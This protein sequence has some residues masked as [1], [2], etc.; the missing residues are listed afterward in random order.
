LHVEVLPQKPR[1]K[2]SSALPAMFP[3]LPQVPKTVVAAFSEADV[4]F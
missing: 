3:F 4:W 2:H 1:V